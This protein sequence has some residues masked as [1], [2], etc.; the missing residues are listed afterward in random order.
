MMIE[1]QSRSENIADTINASY[2]YAQDLIKSMPK[3]K[4]SNHILDLASGFALFSGA[5]SGRLILFN[6][7][8]IRHL[9]KYKYTHL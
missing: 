1:A 5:Y 3:D 2:E 4:I 8:S 7:G 6:L 9:I